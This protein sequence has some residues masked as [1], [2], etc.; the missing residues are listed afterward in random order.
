M[1]VNEFLKDSCDLP[2]IVVKDLFSYSEKD[3]KHKEEVVNKYG[4]YTVRSWGF[5]D[6][7]LVI[8]IRSQ[9]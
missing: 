7:K 5:E 2:T 8:I 1:K 3:F 9:F 6:G 4:Y